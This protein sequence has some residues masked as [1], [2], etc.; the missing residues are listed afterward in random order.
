[1]PSGIVILGTGNVA[2]NFVDA[3]KDT[4]VKV[5]QVYGRNIEKA[6]ELSAKIN[7][8]AINYVSNINPDLQIYFFML[9]D[10]GI[11]ETVKQIKI[12]NG[13]LV[14]TAGSLS[15]DIFK[16]KAENYGVF[17]PF[18][19][20]SKD[21]PVDLGEVPVCIEASNEFTLESLK[22]FA[23]KLGCKAY[24]LNEEKRQY[25]HLSGVFACNFM[26][27]C[28]FLGEKILEEQGIDKEIIRPLLEQSFKKAMAIGAENS[29]TGPAK[30]MDKLII[31]KHLEL[32]K[33]NEQMFDV[34]K[35]LTDSIYKTYR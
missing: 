2:A 20:F 32:L 23:E 17:Y 8:E 19:T 16:G 3:I 26:N 11:V 21:F 27:H 10:T 22:D 35:V 31:E 9:S 30:R 18:Q 1:M 6:R 7:A 5:I 15:M 34:Y 29:Q 12:N 24:R 13:I 25:L 33:N 28:I 4:D 14:H